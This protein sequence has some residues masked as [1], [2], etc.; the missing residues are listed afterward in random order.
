[1]SDASAVDRPSAVSLADLWSIQEG[2]LQSYRAIFITAESLLFAVA[3]FVATVDSPFRGIAVLIIV[4]GLAFVSVWRGV[5]NA[6]ARAVS[7]VHF[8]IQAQESGEP[9]AQPY[10]R[11]REFQEN[12]EARRE[13]EADPRFKA[14]LQS[15]TRKRLDTQ[16][17]ALIVAAWLILL[18][19]VAYGLAK[20]LAL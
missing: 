7:F 9:I 13:V 2:L 16:V 18:A 6:R 12:R 5:C 11:F 20:D 19:V 3:A 10:S 14:L 15:T 17:P 8:M 4:L 1:M